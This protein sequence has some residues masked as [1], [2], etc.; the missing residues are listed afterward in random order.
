[1]VEYKEQDK[2]IITDPFL[3]A[4]HELR[5]PLATIKSYTATLL[6]YDRKLKRDEK[7]EYLVCID[8]TADRLV[9]L[10][11]HY[12]DISRLETGQV[13][14]E[15][16]CTSIPKLITEVVAEA[17]LRA[18]NHRIVSDLENNL[19]MV[20]IDV[21]RIRQVLDNIIDNAIKYSEGKATVVV[22]AR[23]I[24]SSLLVNISDRGVGIPKDELGRVFDKMYRVEQR[25]PSETAGVGLGLTIC[26]ALVEAH[27]GCIWIESEDGEGSTCYFTLPAG[28]EN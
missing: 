15:K 18:P 20:T 24:E 12:L 4:S 6:A 3:V 27:G 14:L 21:K 1:M 10:V 7:R 22:Q 8:E 28:N 13:R 11:N 17:R 9:N 25:V 26:K 5:T 23:K 19:P 16:K 2:S